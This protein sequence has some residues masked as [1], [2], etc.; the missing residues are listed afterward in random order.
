MCK[1][2]RFTRVRDDASLPRISRDGKGLD[3]FAILESDKDFMKVNAG[4]TVLL[5]TG[6][7]P[8]NAKGV[9]MHTF[10]ERTNT[11]EEVERDAYNGE[12]LVKYENNSDKPVYLIKQGIYIGCANENWMILKDNAWV[13]NYPMNGEEYNVVSLNTP[14]MKM[15]M[16]EKQR[17]VVIS[18]VNDSVHM[19]AVN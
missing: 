3:V 6:V 11:W 18:V 10:N 19:K 13:K 15:V 4:D 5:G 17:S 14:I 9:E 1:E 7:F 2:V 12:L 16:S 8:I